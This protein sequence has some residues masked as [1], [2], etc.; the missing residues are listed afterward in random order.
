MNY[1]H[2]NKEKKVGLLKKLEPKYK[3]K[4]GFSTLEGI[5][6]VSVE[7]ILYLRALG[8]YTQVKL[9]NGDKITISKTLK[10]IEGKLPNSNF[11]RCHQSFVVNLAE[12]VLLSDSLVLSSKDVIPISRRRRNEFKRWFVDK[13][14]I[15]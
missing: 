3:S 6:I 10:A 15:V 2:L 4:I 7:K 13:V 8:N 1:L 5:H 9:L 14:N 12:V 11:K